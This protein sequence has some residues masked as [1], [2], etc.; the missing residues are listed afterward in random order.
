[1]Y[2]RFDPEPLAAASTAQVHSARLPDGQEVVVT[3]PRP[4]IDVTVRA[5][6][7]VISDRTTVVER[8]SRP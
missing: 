2:A 7:N 4:D 1:L 8:R 3:V 6:L 5:D